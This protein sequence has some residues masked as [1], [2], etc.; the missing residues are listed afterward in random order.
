MKLLT[1]LFA[2]LLMASAAQAEFFVESVERNESGDVIADVIYY[3][4]AAYP[5]TAFVSNM[6]NKSVGFAV[7]V[8]VIQIGIQPNAYVDCFGPASKKVVKVNLGNVPANA[9]IANGS[10]LGL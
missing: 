9:F 2:S 3:R 7:T 4:C 5:E 8:P 6:D 1:I 10:P